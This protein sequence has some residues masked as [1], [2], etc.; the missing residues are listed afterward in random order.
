MSIKTWLSEF[1]PTSAYHVSAAHAG[2]YIIQKWTGALKQNLDKHDIV[3]V[4]GLPYLVESKEDVAITLRGKNVDNVFCFGH[5]GCPWCIS[6]LRR[7]AAELDIPVDFDDDG[8]IEAMCSFCIGAANGNKPCNRGDCGPY[9]FFMKTGD[10]EPM[11]QWAK[12][13]MKNPKPKRVRDRRKNKTTQEKQD[14]IPEPIPSP[15]RP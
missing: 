6:A 10:P 8:A 4:P 14:G 12:M 1:A 7:A 13:G 2:D 15:D 11:I 3:K 9:E 5:E